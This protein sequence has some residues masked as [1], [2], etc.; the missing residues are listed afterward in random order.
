M[1]SGNTIIE[2]KVLGVVVVVI[3]YNYL[4]N[5]WGSLLMLWARIPL[6]TRCTR[7]NIM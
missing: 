1:Y 3:I 7:Y 6:M 2:P 4:C 5:K